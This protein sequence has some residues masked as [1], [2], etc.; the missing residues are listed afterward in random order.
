MWLGAEYEFGSMFSY[1]IPNFSPSFALSSPIPGPSTIKLAIVA[2]A[3]ERSKNLDYGKDIFDII[4][5]SK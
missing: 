2:T 3:I 4:K 5:S 1:R